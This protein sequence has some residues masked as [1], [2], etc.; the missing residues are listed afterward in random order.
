VLCTEEPF[1]PVLFTPAPRRLVACATP[2]AAALRVPWGLALLSGSV[3]APFTP[4]VAMGGG[5]GVKSCARRRV[6]GEV[7]PKLL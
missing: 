2:A 7:S 5:S 3:E 1:T 4:A 6:V